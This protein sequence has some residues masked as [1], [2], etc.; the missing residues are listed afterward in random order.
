MG[1]GVTTQ[2]RISRRTEMGKRTEVENKERKLSVRT[3]DPT[4]SV[5]FSEGKTL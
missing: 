5:P 2:R 1:C 4:I 3:K